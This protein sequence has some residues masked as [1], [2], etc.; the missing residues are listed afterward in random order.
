ML[1][2]WRR[3]ANSR[4]NFSFG[5]ENNVSIF[6]FSLFQE[7]R[8]SVYHSKRSNRNAGGMHP[9]AVSW[10]GTSCPDR[11]HA[12][13]VLRD[14]TPSL[15]GNMADTGGPRPGSWNVGKLLENDKKFE[16]LQL[17]ARECCTALYPSVQPW[18]LSTERYDRSVSMKT[19]LSRTIFIFPVG[20]VYT[21]D[22]HTVTM[23]I[24][25]NTPFQYNQIYYGTETFQNNTF[26][27]KVF[28]QVLLSHV[29][30]TGSVAQH[31][32][33]TTPSNTY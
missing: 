18:H 27:S 23:A 21:R 15:L 30:P 33:P 8:E 32:C 1:W 9:V 6:H 11:L 25:L 29:L 28:P 5:K 2:Y 22:W 7:K 10:T 31:P 16:V 19:T 20:F 17:P 3:P 4:N 26:K 24:K 13:G 14:N 12:A